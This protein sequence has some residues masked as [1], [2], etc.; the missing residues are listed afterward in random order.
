[1]AM[2][3]V[4]EDFAIFEEIPDDDNVENRDPKNGPGEVVGLGMGLHHFV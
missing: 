2:V 4:E 1:M 3:V